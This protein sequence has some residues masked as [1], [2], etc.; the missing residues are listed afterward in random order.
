MEPLRHMHSS[1]GGRP[2]GFCYLFT[3]EP[4]WLPAVSSSLL[5]ISDLGKPLVHLHSVRKWTRVR[6]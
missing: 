6:G 2:H 1:S 4:A 5:P 3:P